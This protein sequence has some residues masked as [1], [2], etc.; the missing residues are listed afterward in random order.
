M[1]NALS[2][3]RNLVL[4]PL[5]CR[6]DLSVDDFQLKDSGFVDGLQLDSVDDCCKACEGGTA[7]TACMDEGTEGM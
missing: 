6:A 2:S 4:S 3:F 5:Y 7:M 1:M